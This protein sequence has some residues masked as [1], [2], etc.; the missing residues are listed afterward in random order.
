[1]ATPGQDRRLPLT[2]QPWPCVHR[3]G[4]V[5]CLGR[6]PQPCSPPGRPTLWD[7][8]ASVCPTRPSLRP[9]TPP[10]LFCTDTT[11][12]YPEWGP[13]AQRGADPSS[14]HL[15]G[16]QV[17]STGSI[18]GGAQGCPP[19]PG[20]CEH[21]RPPLGA[22]NVGLAHVSGKAREHWVSSPRPLPPAIP[23]MAAPAGVP[24]QWLASGHRHRHCH[25]QQSLPSV[26][27]EPRLSGSRCGSQRP[28][29][30]PSRLGSPPRP[31]HSDLVLQSTQRA[32]A[33]TP[34]YHTG[35]PWPH[36]HFQSPGLLAGPRAAR[37][38]PGRLLL[39]CAL[40]RSA[41]RTG[42]QRETKSRGAAPRREV[43]S[44]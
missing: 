5:W 35:R 2:P 18:G 16:M 26:G 19:A 6:R 25:Q 3:A 42:G 30:A 15:S 27:A 9:P 17:R 33:H 34:T 28:H 40:T 14:A 13:W 39:N 24:R 21:P 43:A 38:G 7:A 4:R 23:W 10:H 31:P 11:E 32:A 12:L 1:M 44:A 29:A 20:Y 22:G 37:R 36:G 41:L 8:G